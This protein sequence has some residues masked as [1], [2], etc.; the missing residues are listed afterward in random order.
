MSASRM[1]HKAQQIVDQ[2]KAEAW[3]M[4]DLEARLADQFPA[5][6]MDTEAHREIRR[7]AIGLYEI[8]LAEQQ[9]RM[10]QLQKAQA[11]PE[12][13][14][15]DWKLTIAALKPGMVIVCAESENKRKVVVEEIIGTSSGLTIRVA[16]PSGLRYRTI[17]GPRNTPLA[18]VPQLLAVPD[19]EWEAGCGF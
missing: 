4:E 2:A 6:G 14:A 13:N 1:M 17:S 5:K 10:P 16:R 15:N 9:E 3:P 12:P 11:D 18:N 8:R 19:L 7:W